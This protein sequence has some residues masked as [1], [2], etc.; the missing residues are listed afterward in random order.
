[1]AGQR[2]RSTVRMSWMAAPV[3]EVI[4]PSCATDCR[5]GS[6]ARGVEQALRQQPGLELFKGGLQGPGPGVF[7][8]FDNQLK[9]APAFIQRHPAAQA[10]RVAVG[11]RELHPLVARAEHGAAHLGIAILEGEVPVSGGGHDEIADFALHP[12]KVKVTLQQGLGLPVELAD[13]EQGR[14][15]IRGEG[16]VQWNT[17]PG[18]VF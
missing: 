1:M 17:G 18:W 6:F 7:Q 5:Q 2:R 16:V 10:Y 9:L 8:V 11:G 4:T 15:L 12:D 3:G 13:R 14:W